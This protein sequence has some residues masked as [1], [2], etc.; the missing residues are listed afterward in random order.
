MMSSSDV[1]PY[2]YWLRNHGFRQ[3]LNGGSWRNLL[4]E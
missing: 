1:L 4:T 3:V 2:A